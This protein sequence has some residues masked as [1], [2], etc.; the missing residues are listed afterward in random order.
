MSYLTRFAVALGLV[1]LMPCASAATTAIQPSGESAPATTDQAQLPASRIH[2]AEV[3]Y[4]AWLNRIEQRNAIAGLATAIV[5]G[6]TPVFERTLGYADTTTREPVTVDT[7]FRLA[8]LS[9]AFS[10]A[11][12]AQLIQSGSF[13]WNTP[14]SSVL[15]DFHLKTLSA[16]EQ[17]TVADI[18]GQ[19]TGLPRNTYDNLI[20][21]NQSFQSVVGALDQVDLMCPVG[22]CYSYQ[23]V[24]YSLI[25]EVVQ[26]ETGQ[27]LPVEVEH[28]LFQPLGM[29]TASYGLAP[30]EASASWARPHHASAHGWIPIKPSEVYYHVAPAAGVNASLRDMEKWLAAQ[31]GE[32]PDVLNPSEL[33]AVHAP[34]IATPVELRSTPWRKAR[35]QSAHYAM[36]WRVFT[37]AGE[38]LIF[39]AGVVDGY[40]TMIGFF[41][42]YRVGV[43]TLWNSSGFIPS[44]L[45]PMVF[46]SLLGLKH[47]DWAGI[48]Q[49]TPLAGRTMARATVR[50]AGGPGRARLASR[51][52]RPH[53]PHTGHSPRPVL[54]NARDSA[55]KPISK[56]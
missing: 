55:S 29:R 1:A 15:P 37:Y 45:M 25:G 3:D 31:M 6:H 33:Q 19:R 17:A 4:A 40:R 51:S 44:G 26:H 7:V 28:K 52:R 41:P 32:R 38:T 54:A 16:T 18:L 23:N 50:H 13:H 56:D 34:G 20:E 39:H 36:G 9:K 53:P 24:A 46:D 10:S 5:V 2:D 42:K 14:L 48:E 21:A 47:E 22:Q 8:S 30:L 27:P 43:V 12:A 11:L 49:D 35:L